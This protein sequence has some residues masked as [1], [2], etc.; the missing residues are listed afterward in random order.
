MARATTRLV[1]QR[2]TRYLLGELPCQP[3][4]DDGQDRHSRDVAA[5]RVAGIVNDLLGIAVV[6][7]VL[8]VEI[9]PP[10]G[11]SPLESLREPNVE[12]PERR[13]PYRVV[14]PEDRLVGVRSL[15]EIA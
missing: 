9:D 7:H 2:A 5:L 12:R 10:V 13:D 15:V 4:T 11:P 6:G 8:H 14:R 1:K 3:R